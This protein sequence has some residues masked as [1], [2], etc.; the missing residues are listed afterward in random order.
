M[1]VTG[2]QDAGRAY[3]RSERRAKEEKKKKKDKGAEATYVDVAVIYWRCVKSNFLDINV[4]LDRASVEL[5]SSRWQRE[6]IIM[7][8]TIRGTVSK[9]TDVM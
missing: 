4:R 9:M 3:A 8:I 1:H 5:P 2:T 6:M 7:R